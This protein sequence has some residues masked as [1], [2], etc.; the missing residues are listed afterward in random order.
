MSP[1]ARARRVALLLALAG[2]GADAPSAPPPPV[3]VAGSYALA[4]VSG[5]SLP[6]VDHVDASHDTIYVD[7]SSLTLGDDQ[8][9]VESDA[10]HFSQGGTSSVTTTG[11]WS[12][13]GS[14]VTLVAAGGSVSGT[15]GD[16][17]LTMQRGGRGWTYARR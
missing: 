6:A 13:A 9:F 3:I 2:C 7:A 14:T 5:A 4:S 10:Y 8:R 15:L 1:H 17:S 12:V 11:T 16:A